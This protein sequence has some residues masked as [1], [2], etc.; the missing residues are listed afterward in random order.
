MSDPN[1]PPWATLADSGSDPNIPPWAVPADNARVGAAPAKNQN[2]S[3]ARSG[4]NAI[5]ALAG[6]GGG[7]IGGAGG[8]VFGVGVGGVPGAIGGAAIAGAGGEAVKQ[9]IV[10]AFPALGDAP[11]TAGEALSGIGAEALRQGALE[12][13][14]RTLG[15][16]VRGAGK[17]L[18]KAALRPTPTLKGRFPNVVDVAVGEGRIPL[19]SAMRDG[20]TNSINTNRGRL[21][22]MG[23]EMDVAL[24]NAL[25]NGNWYSPDEFLGT[26]NRELRSEVKSNPLRVRYMARLRSMVEDYK[27]G[28]RGPVIPAKPASAILD[29]SGSPAIAAEPARQ[30]FPKGEPLSP[31]SVRRM[32][33]SA[34]KTAAPIFNAGARGADPGATRAM[35]GEFQKAIAGDARSA[36]SKLPTSVKGQNVAALDERMQNLIGLKQALLESSNR[37]SGSG[38][39]MLPPALSWMIPSGIRSPEFLY[40]SALALTGTGLQQTLRQSPRILDEVLFNLFSGNNGPTQV[41]GR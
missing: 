3:W 4:V 39:P 10:R 30:V 38:V 15:W 2:R 24:D 16:A 14:G 9:N 11:G 13:G 18:M 25:K 1:I 40:P 28:W 34:Q 6:M 31:R 7:L 12:A 33:R 37:Y 26:V 32:K 27:R 41:G 21:K 23:K 17:G 35:E 8:T 5:P 29:A 20:I 36:L 22:G 19:R